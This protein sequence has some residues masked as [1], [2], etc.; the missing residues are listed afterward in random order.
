[1]AKPHVALACSAKAPPYASLMG[2]T[3]FGGPIN[4]A[5]WRG[6]PKAGSLGHNFCCAEDCSSGFPLGACCPQAPCLLRWAFC[7]AKRPILRAV[8]AHDS[9]SQRSSAAPSARLTTYGLG[10]QRLLLPRRTMG[11]GA[12][13]LSYLVD[14]KD[15]SGQAL[16]RGL[17]G[18]LRSKEAYPTVR[19]ALPPLTPRPNRRLGVYSN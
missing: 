19:G 9:A 17:G 12:S 15:R 10:P 18:L 2:L 5:L 11:G 13:Q 3:A 4:K 1:M 6:A 16:R 8:A 14:A 7:G